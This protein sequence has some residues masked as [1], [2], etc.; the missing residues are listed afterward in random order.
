MRINDII[1]DQFVKD[2]IQEHINHTFDLEENCYADRFEYPEGSGFQWKIICEY[3][4]EEK[5]ELTIKLTR[6]I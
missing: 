4:N 3:K 1:N 6:R 2:K 5:D